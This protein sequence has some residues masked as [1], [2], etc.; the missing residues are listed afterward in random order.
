MPSVRHR[1]AST[2]GPFAVS[3]IIVELAAADLSFEAF[4]ECK[5]VHF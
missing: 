3:I 2:R 1:C 5:P 4:Y